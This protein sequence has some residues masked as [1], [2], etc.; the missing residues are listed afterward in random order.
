MPPST[1]F[2]LQVNLVLYKRIAY[3]ITKN[4]MSKRT[5]TSCSL[6]GPHGFHEDG[7]GGAVGNMGG[8]AENM[9]FLSTA[10]TPTPLPLSVIATSAATRPAPPE[11]RAGCCQSIANRSPHDAPGSLKAAA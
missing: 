6:S 5:T 8:T 3:V 2:C 10:V 11:T 9:V 4:R 7:G 1:A